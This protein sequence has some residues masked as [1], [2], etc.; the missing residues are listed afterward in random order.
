MAPKSPSFV[1]DLHLQGPTAYAG[2]FASL[3]RPFNPVISCPDT[4]FLQLSYGHDFEKPCMAYKIFWNPFDYEINYNPGPMIRRP[5]S[6]GLNSFPM[7]SVI[8]QPS[9][10]CHMSLV[11]AFQA[12]LWCLWLICFCLFSLSFK[13]WPI[14]GVQAETQYLWGPQRNELCILPVCVSVLWTKWSTTSHCGV[15][16][17]L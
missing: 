16:L 6:Y 1:N 13:S 17:C 8:L 14:F 9:L 7:S 10:S 5:L 2:P 11:T 3:C 12:S 15:L 4:P